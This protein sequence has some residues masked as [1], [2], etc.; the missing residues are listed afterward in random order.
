MRKV[1]FS[2]LQKFSMD[3]NYNIALNPAIELNV[4]DSEGK[5]PV[6]IA[7]ASEKLH[8]LLKRV[9]AMGGSATVFIKEP[10]KVSMLQFVNEGYTP[11]ENY[12]ENSLSVKTQ[13]TVN[14]SIE[15]FLNYLR[16]TGKPLKLS[17]ELSYSCP[18]STVSLPEE[19]VLSRV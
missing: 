16:T 19:V 11:A 13:P 8:L 17:S 7:L 2:K 3:V 10:R 1:K 12:I 9:S 6:V 15:V 4:T 5:H 18:N 14:S